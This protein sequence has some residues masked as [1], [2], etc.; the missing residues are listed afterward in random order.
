MKDDIKID[1]VYCHTDSKISLSWIKATHKEFQ[2]FVENRVNEVRKKVLPENWFYVRTDD[3]PADLLTRVDNDG[4]NNR[5]WWDGSKFLQSSNM[6]VDEYFEPGEEEMKEFEKEV[7]VKKQNTLIINTEE[8][9]SVDNI[10]DINKFSDMLK[11]LRITSYVKRFVDNLKRKV[12]KIDP[13]LSKY[14]SAAEMCTA[15]NMW[16]KANQATLS[17]Q[18]GYEQTKVQ[19]NCVIDEEGLV[20]CQGRM[21]DRFCYRNLIDSQLW[22][23]FTVIRRCCIESNKR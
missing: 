16:I 18:S 14:P 12:N 21:N 7:K 1:N 20:R 8:K 13:V 9:P 10:I 15:R 22:S 6:Y 17:K 19:L 23:F 3:N 5:L 4:L 11:L 2:V